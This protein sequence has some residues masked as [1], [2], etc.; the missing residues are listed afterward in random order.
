MIEESGFDTRQGQ[1]TFL[2]A[3]FIQGL[4]PSCHANH[5][6]NEAVNE[7]ICVGGG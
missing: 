5:L 6:F 1:Y 2:S 7:K 4:E 3:E